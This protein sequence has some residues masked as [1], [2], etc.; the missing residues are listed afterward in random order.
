[1]MMFVLNCSA[2]TSIG[3]GIDTIMMIVACEDTNVSSDNDM[4]DVVFMVYGKPYVPGVE[5]I[6]EGTPITKKTTVRYMI[7]DLGATDDFDFND[8]VIDVNHRGPLIALPVIELY[9]C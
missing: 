3:H 4:N 8:I 5:T 6:E 7:E 2:K 9:N 1:M